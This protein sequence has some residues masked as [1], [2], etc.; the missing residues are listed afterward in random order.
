MRS[1]ELA[2]AVYARLI[3]Y[4]ELTAIRGDRLFDHVPPTEIPLGPNNEGFPYQTMGE[5]TSVSLDTDDSE[6]AEGTLTIHSWS[7]Y[8]GTK[9]IRQMQDATH[10]ALHR[11]SLSVTGA[12]F[13]TI[14][15]DFSQILTDPDGITRHGIM[16][17]RALLDEV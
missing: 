14:E 1:L 12:N 10:R 15:Y 16:R 13:I 11:Y 17:F 2:K 8:R 9:E 4:A 5:E 3:D 7:T 6:G